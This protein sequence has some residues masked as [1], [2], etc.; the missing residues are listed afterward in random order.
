[1]NSVNCL[2]T[3]KERATLIGFIQYRRSCAP[4]G[5]SKAWLHHLINYN[6]WR[7]DED[8]KEA[9][10]VSRHWLERTR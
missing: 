9:F 2:G 4:F 7:L 6:L 8:I 10:Q 5:Y 3:I 1:M